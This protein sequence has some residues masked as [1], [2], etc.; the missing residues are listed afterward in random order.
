MRS[1][2]RTKALNYVRHGADEFFEG[3]PARVDSPHRKGGDRHGAFERLVSAT[4]GASDI[5]GASDALSDETRESAPNHATLFL[6]CNASGYQPKEL[7]AELIYLTSIK[8]CEH[9][10]QHF[11]T[12][13]EVSHE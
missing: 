13:K 11:G 10:R 9:P 4:S 2:K 6:E 12:S 1:A 8:N 5:S 3:A 7:L